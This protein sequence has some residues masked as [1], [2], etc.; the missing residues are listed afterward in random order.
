MQVDKR[1]SVGLLRF[2]VG[3]NMSGDLHISELGH[4]CMSLSSKHKDCKHWDAKLKV[5][6]KQGTH[7]LRYGRRRGTT[8]GRGLVVANTLHSARRSWTFCRHTLFCTIQ[9]TRALLLE[10]ILVRKMELPIVWPFAFSVV[11]SIKR[12]GRAE[13]R[14]I[15]PPPAYCVSR[16]RFTWNSVSG[17]LP[18]MRAVELDK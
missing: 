5:R 8:S 2:P 6:S 3:L 13:R 4:H 10:H 9:C 16:A 12:S 11:A 15:L 7:V 17:L 14:S 18:G 1:D